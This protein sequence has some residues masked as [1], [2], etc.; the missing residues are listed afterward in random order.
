MTEQQRNATRREY[1]AA[2]ARQNRAQDPEAAR[3][4]QRETERRRAT[5]R[6]AWKRAY[7]AANLTHV[8]QLGRAAQQKATDERRDVVTAIKLARGCADCSYNRHHAA[9]D[10]D[11][12]DRAEKHRT[13]S[14]LVSH[15]SP[16]STLM[17]EIDKCDVVCANC[18]RIRSF[19]RRDWTALAPVAAEAGQ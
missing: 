1:K 4:K 17:A 6:A 10:F 19:D 12:R 9:L 5:E 15:N 7:R 8:R 18:H 2:W 11:H 14:W 16:W 13:V 3:A